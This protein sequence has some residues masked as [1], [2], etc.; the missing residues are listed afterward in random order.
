MAAKA[1]LI[2][3]RRVNGGVVGTDRLLTEHRPEN[4]HALPTH[5][6]LSREE[7][8][9]A[10]GGVGSGLD[11]DDPVMTQIEVEVVD[12]PARGRVTCGMATIC[13]N[14]GMASDDGKIPLG[15][16]RAATAK[17]SREY[18]AR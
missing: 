4:S 9:P 11:A 2:K 13:R 8:T 12:S 3:D 17:K 6:L 16:H 5:A 10:G 1:A 14:T 7:E 15:V 18:G